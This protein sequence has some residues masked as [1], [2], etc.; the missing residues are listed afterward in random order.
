[1]T[2]GSKAT[3]GQQQQTQEQESEEK[4]KS[5]A[6]GLLG[7]RKALLPYDFRHNEKSTE[8]PWRGKVEE[9]QEITTSPKLRR[10]RGRNYDRPIYI[11]KKAEDTCKQARAGPAEPRISAFN[12]DSGNLLSNQR[13]T[14]KQAPDFTEGQVENVAGAQLRRSYM[15]GTTSSTQASRRNEL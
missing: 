3:F 8:N 14:Q 13:N 1:M 4:E 9:E 11:H 12:T 10:L 7:S 6:E 5:K 15:E 2:S